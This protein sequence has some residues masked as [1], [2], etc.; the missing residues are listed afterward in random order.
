MLSSYNDYYY[1]NHNTNH[2]NNNYYH[3]N[4]HIY[5]DNHY[6]SNDYVYDINVVNH[7]DF[8]SYHYDWYNYHGH[9]YDRNTVFLYRRGKQP[10]ST[11]PR[12]K[13][14]ATRF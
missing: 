7:F 3:T 5:Y 4:D 8:Y 6:H 10:S 13:H 9:N 11:N 2:D 14:V 12:S 1:I